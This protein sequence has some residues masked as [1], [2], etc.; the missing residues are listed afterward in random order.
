MYW[1]KRINFDLRGSYKTRCNAAVVAFNTGKPISHISYNL[2]TKP[3][4]IAAQLENNK[5]VSVS[6]TKKR[7]TQRYVKRAVADR[8]YGLQTDKL[9]A[10]SAEI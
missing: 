8:D 10:T 9:D 4:E 5:K 3:W 6:N 1:W 7:S 2:V